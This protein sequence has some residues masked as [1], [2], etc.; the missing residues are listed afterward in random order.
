MCEALVGKRALTTDLRQLGFVIARDTENEI[1]RLWLRGYLY[2]YLSSI[3]V[4][5]YEYVIGINRGR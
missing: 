1:E 5:L 2:G 4:V 3:R